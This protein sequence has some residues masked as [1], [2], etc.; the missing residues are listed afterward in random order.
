[1]SSF[2]RKF[3]DSLAKYQISLAKFHVS[4]EYFK[5]HR[6]TSYFFRKILSLFRKILI[7]FE[8]FTFFSKISNFVRKFRVSIWIW[9]LFGNLFPAH[10]KILQNMTLNRKGNPRAFPSL[11]HHGA[12]VSNRSRIRSSSGAGFPNLASPR[13]LCGRRGE[14]VRSRRELTSMAETRQCVGVSLTSQR[15]MT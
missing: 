6:K 4:F 14:L 5:F 12:R 8:T 11:S 3:H 2:F 10:F 13:A 1:M 7:S 9:S 15:T